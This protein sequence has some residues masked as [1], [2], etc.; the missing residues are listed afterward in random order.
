MKIWSIRCTSH[1]FCPPFTQ[2]AIWN[3]NSSSQWL[4][5]AGWVARSS[6]LFGGRQQQH[7]TLRNELQDWGFRHHKEIW[8]I[9]GSDP[10]RWGRESSDDVQ[11][12]RSLYQ[13][14]WKG[15]EGN[16]GGKF[17]WGKP[18]LQSSV[19]HD[20]KLSCKW[21]DC[22]GNHALLVQGEV[23]GFPWNWVWNENEGGRRGTSVSISRKTTT[24][25]SILIRL[26]CREAP[27]REFH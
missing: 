25:P 2:H 7:P 9:T 18:V 17:G 27:L 14:V 23:F 8:W 12:H 5:W 6:F 16:G 20:K 15:E 10:A 13:H 3:N 22:S 21:S 11:N 26:N 1:N 24:A 19:L 4:S